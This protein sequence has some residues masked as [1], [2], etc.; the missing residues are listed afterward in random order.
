MSLSMDNQRF[1]LCRLGACWCALELAGLSEVMRPQPVDPVAGLP[2]F[3]EG[4]SIIRGRPI[5]VIDL[6]L[7]VCGIAASLS[8]QSRFVSVDL[9]GGR[10][11]LRVDEVGGVQALPASIW[12]A[13]PELVEKGQSEHLSALGCLDGELIVRLGRARL[14]N[15][16][17]W[18]ALS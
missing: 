16:E 11:A 8:G 5:P 12:W 2:A 1:L 4:L 6:P 18:E 15:S 17:Q 14:L 3:V 13:L 7:L 10:L 9:D